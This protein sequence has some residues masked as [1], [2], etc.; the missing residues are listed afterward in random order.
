MNTKLSPLYI[1]ELTRHTDRASTVSGREGGKKEPLKQPKKQAKEMGEEDQAFRPKQREKQ[2]KLG[3]LKAK[4]M[5][6]GPLATGGIKKSGK[7]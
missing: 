5:G 1:N 6:R 3:K 2:K 4:A 7:K